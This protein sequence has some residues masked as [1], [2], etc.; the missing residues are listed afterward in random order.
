MISVESFKKAERLVRLR[1]GL[2]E[3]QTALSKADM[4][5]VEARDPTNKE[6]AGMFLPSIWVDGK[7]KVSAIIELLQGEAARQLAETN[8]ALRDFGIELGIEP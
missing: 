6:H 5:R 3:F 7:F 2:I 1:N 8:A 4:L